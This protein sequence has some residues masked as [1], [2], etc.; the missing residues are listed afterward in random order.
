MKQLTLIRDYKTEATIGRL[1]DSD[2]IEICK[3]LE[4][5]KFYRQDDFRRDDPKTTDN[6]SCCIPEGEYEVEY[7]LS[8]RLKRMTFEVLNIP[9][10]W[11][12]IRFHS[13]NWVNELLGCIA[14]ATIIGIN[15]VGEHKYMAQESSKAE[16]KLVNFIG[17]PEKFNLKITSNNTQC[18]VNS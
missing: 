11:Q 2:G 14:P 4:R 1:I 13:A 12:G 3:T 16:K 6:E 8:P 9:G 15:D 10:G 5:P 17:T 18:N 7:T